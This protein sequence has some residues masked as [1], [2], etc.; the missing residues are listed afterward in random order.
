M[1]F[2]VAPRD[3]IEVAKLQGTRESSAIRE[4]L[5]LAL[6]NSYKKNMFLLITSGEMLRRPEKTNLLFIIKLISIRGGP[7][8]TYLI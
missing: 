6:G 3:A 2:T 1:S 4:L 5:K 7:N 8:N